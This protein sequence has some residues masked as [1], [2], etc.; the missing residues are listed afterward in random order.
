MVF[1]EEDRSREIV[2]IKTAAHHRLRFGDRITVHGRY[3]GVD[4]RLAPPTRNYR[5]SLIEIVSF[6]P[7]K[8]IREVY[9]PIPDPSL[10]LPAQV[11]ISGTVRNKILRRGLCDV[12]V[13]AN[14]QRV[15]VVVE[16][17]SDEF[18]SPVERGDVASFVGM[19]LW[20]VGGYFS[21]STDHDCQPQLTLFVGNPDGARVEESPIFVDAQTIGLAVVATALL[22][23]AG[24]VWLRMLR[25]QV[26][27]RT[28]RLNAANSYL[29]TSFEAARQA[30]LLSDH[31]RRV[32]RVNSRFTDLFGFVPA[33]GE[34]LR[35]CLDRIARYL[36]TDKNGTFLDLRR[37]A[38]ERDSRSLVGT[39]EISAGDRILQTYVS[40]IKDAEG[41]YC[42][43]LL[44][45]E[46]VTENRRLENELLHARKMEAVGQLAGGVAHDFNNL[47]TVIIS[48]LTL[49][50]EV[51]IEGGV[52][53]SEFG[54]PI[55]MAV[56]RG[57][58]L[59]RKLLTFS[60]K[61]QVEIR[62]VE[63]NVLLKRVF[64]L[65]RR[66]F[67]SSVQ[68]SLVLE[69]SAPTIRIDEVSVEQVLLN[70]CINARDAL[71]D[72]QGSIS[73]RTK[74]SEHPTLGRTACLE[75]EDDG[76]GMKPEVKER[77][78]EPFFT[79]KQRGSGTGLGLSAALGV[80]EQLGGKIECDST[81]QLGTTFRLYF[82]CQGEDRELIQSAPAK[83]QRI[84]PANRGL[85]LLLVDDEEPLRVSGKFLLQALGHQVFT[86][87][88][89]REAIER[90]EEGAVDLVLL[91]LTMPEMTGSEAYRVI[92]DRW[93]DT[94][95]IFCSGYSPERISALVRAESDTAF[96]AKPFRIA[97]ISSAI[98][99][100]V[101]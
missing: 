28:R 6:E 66:T 59:T 3:E 68:L 50:E 24:F 36:E 42:G 20:N 56:R 35:N 30:I 17:P 23:A 100:L 22:A 4:K 87:R 32:V 74:L 98:E 44:S 92:R 101:H 71:L 99:Q 72:G 94:P 55:E 57:A 25:I 90:L 96:I 83:A 93:P 21:R 63:A 19:P 95:V 49:L 54:Q 48:N 62:S 81:W 53:P 80:V 1:V 47:L 43:H 86:A 65:V 70:I 51:A 8:T 38:F 97:E 2:K 5:A 14:D 46:D 27:V 18:G 78:F 37:Q 16:C 89:G 67:D 84:A 9:E 64:G 73:M 26:R 82:P 29:A 10:L 15:R 41:L 85:R 45:F 7:P 58:D 69:P 75:I 79:T 77:I 40:P 13:D 31:Q 33:P 52:D 91:D 60:R 34:P 12:L 11:K 88:N 61:S 76:I 39:V